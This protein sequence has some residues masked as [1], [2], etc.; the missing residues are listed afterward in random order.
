LQVANTRAVGEALVRYINQGITLGSVNLPEINI[1]SLTLEEPNHARVIYIH[2]NVPGVL[3]KVNEILGNHNVD[4]Q[5]SDSRGDIAYLIADV[6][7]V[8]TQDIKDI[9]DS[10]EGLSCKCFFPDSKGP[11]AQTNN[12]IARIMTRVLY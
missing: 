8:R 4:K 10:L 5:I 12:E 1:R 2:Q 6:S 11:Q 3:R 7:E 9:S